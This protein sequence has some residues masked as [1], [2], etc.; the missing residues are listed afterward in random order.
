MLSVVVAAVVGCCVVLARSDISGA[1]VALIAPSPMP[2]LV[3]MCMWLRPCERQA[4]NNE[5]EGSA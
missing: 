1:A 2:W 4:K 3:A 5:S